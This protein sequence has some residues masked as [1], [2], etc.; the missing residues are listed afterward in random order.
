M[1]EPGKFG[2]TGWDGRVAVTEAIGP[3][4]TVDG[5]TY[6]LLGKDENGSKVYQDAE[7]VKEQNVSTKGETETYAVDKTL[8]NYLKIKEKIVQYKRITKLLD[9]GITIML[10]ESKTVLI[11][12]F[13]MKNRQDRPLKQETDLEQKQEI[14][15]LTKKPE[16]YWIAK[17]QI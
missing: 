12:I 5:K 3:N 13:L 6:A 2:M 15:C 1:T 14:E 10:L 8:K 11:P 9:N 16:N 17:D 7:V 4:V